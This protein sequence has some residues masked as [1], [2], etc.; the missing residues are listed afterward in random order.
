MTFMEVDG[1]IR[2]YIPNLITYFADFWSRWPEGR[3]AVILSDALKMQ[4]AYWKNAGKI[5]NA[6][7]CSKAATAIVDHANTK[8]KTEDIRKKE[9]V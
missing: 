4:A 9:M 1:I 7:E 6:D 3:N 2:K 8:V 5:N